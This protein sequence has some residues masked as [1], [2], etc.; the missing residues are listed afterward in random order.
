MFARRQREW[1]HVW[2]NEVESDVTIS[3][4]SLEKET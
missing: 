1:W 2:W 3:P 4:L